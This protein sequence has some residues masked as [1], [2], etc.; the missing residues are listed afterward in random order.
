MLEVL[1]LVRSVGALPNILY[2]LCYDSDILAHGIRHAAGVAD[3]KAYLEKIVQ[4]TIPVPR[5]ETFQLRHWFE[6]T[7][8]RFAAPRDEDG[9]ARLK[10]I[11]DIE[12]GR[13]LTT[14]RAVVRALDALRFLWPTLD[15]AGVDL[16]DLVW[17]QLI[18]D[19]NP[20]LY[21]WVEE[22]CATAAELSLGTAR[23][24]DEERTVMLEKLLDAAGKDWFVS[25][26]Y[27][28][29][30]AE[31]LPGLD[32][33]YDKDGPM[34]SLFTNVGERE[35]NLAIV[36]R[37]LASPDHYRLYFALADPSHALKQADF[38]AFWTASRESAQAVAQ[39][40]V[41]MYTPKPP[42]SLGKVDILLERIRGSDPATL[43]RD[44]CSHI[45]LGFADVLD[46]LYGIRPFE[47]FWVTSLWDR[48]E[49]MIA[50][51]LQ[52]LDPLQRT[53]TVDAMFAEGRAI[54]WLT[55]LFRRETFAHGRAGVR[56]KPESERYFTASQ[57]D[58]IGAAMLARYGAMTL[59]AILAAI[60]P[61][62][63]LFAWVQ[64]GAA[65]RVRSLVAEETI[66]DRQFLRLLD[67]LLSTITTSEGSYKALNSENVAPFLDP[68]AVRVRLNGIAT[69]AARPD[70][71]EHAQTLLNAVETAKRF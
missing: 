23:V 29:Y 67:A 16:A 51:L 15:K 24:E 50:P 2:L 46:D 26:H 1:R 62:D 59:D 11:V 36:G 52:R 38:D 8:A 6:D 7:L 4:L 40:L 19:D 33:N 66:E 9:V 71:A 39:A 35:R 42:R 30:F 22:Y 44:Q 53:A 68:D 49:R 28:H 45:L 43:T 47:R 55:T 21:R 17:L 61:M 10:L 41:N 58:R 20:S 32:L 37:R 12:G 65:E 18:K 34:F 54:S 25:L 27:R 63:I 70:L 69:D 13:R 60:A 5:P 57:L 48:A 3:G 14:P 56:P 64:G 31:Q